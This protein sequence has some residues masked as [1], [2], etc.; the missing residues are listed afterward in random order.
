MPDKPYQGED[1]HP[2]HKAH[3]FAAHPDHSPDSLLKMMGAG[4]GMPEMMT[5]DITY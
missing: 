4:S 1:Q 2:G 3:G 5:Q